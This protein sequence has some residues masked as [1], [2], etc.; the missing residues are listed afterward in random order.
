[1]SEWW[2]TN[3]SRL[4][5]KPLETLV[6]GTRCRRRQ[7]KRWIDWQHGAC[8]CCVKISRNKRKRQPIGMLGR[9]SG[10]HDW[11]LANASNC[12]SCGFRLRNARNASDYVWMETGLQSGMWQENM[13]RSTFQSRP[14]TGFN[15]KY[16][17][18]RCP[19]KPRVQVKENMANGTLW[20]TR[21][22][23][24]IFP[25]LTGFRCCYCI[26]WVIIIPVMRHCTFWACVVHY[27]S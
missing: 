10:N 19:Q 9:S 2:T 23:L 14:L 27:G 26:W 7:N 18:G 25:R 17:S 5:A 12:V 22:Y 6:S 15:H 11:L 24:T 16:H 3:N 8:V 20:P 1:M 21:A 4:P 13:S